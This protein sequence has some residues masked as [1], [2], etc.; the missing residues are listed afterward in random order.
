MRIKDIWIPT[1]DGTTE[2]FA[3]LQF[4][5]VRG[6]YKCVN[7]WGIKLKGSK[8]MKTKIDCSKFPGLRGM[9]VEGRIKL[10]ENE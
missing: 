2:A 3:K 6:E 9:I 5:K 8:V 7:K 1:C 4:N 10:G